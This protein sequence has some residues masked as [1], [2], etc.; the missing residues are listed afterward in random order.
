MPL[1]EDAEDAERPG[2]EAG[3]NGRVLR[4]AEGTDGGIFG[5]R[6]AELRTAT[7]DRFELRH[8]LVNGAFGKGGA[9]LLPQDALAAPEIAR[10]G[11][12]HDKRSRIQS[13]PSRR[14]RRTSSAVYHFPV[15]L[16]SASA[17][18]AS[19]TISSGVGSAGSR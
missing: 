3:E 2:L 10:S 5:D 18:N 8:Q 1:G 11:L 14:N 7:G 13:S 4:V 15:A 17:S 9:A 6:R 16:A 12:R 19:A